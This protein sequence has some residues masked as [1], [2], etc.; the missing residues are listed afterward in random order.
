MNM[1][2]VRV[3]VW[4]RLNGRVGVTGKAKGKGKYKRIDGIGVRK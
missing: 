3:G 4:V 2:R 1:V